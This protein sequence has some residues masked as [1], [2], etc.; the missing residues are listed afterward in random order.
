MGPIEYR[1]MYSLSTC[2]LSYLLRVYLHV[3]SNM[4]L[5]QGAQLEKVLK[6]DICSESIPWEK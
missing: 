6:R 2:A 3:I 1:W 5:C 4:V